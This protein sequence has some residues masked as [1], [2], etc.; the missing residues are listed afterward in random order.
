MRAYKSLAWAALGASLLSGCATQQAAKVEASADRVAREAEIKVDQPA[1]LSSIRS[2]VIYEDRPWIPSSEVVIKQETPWANGD[3]EVT[4]V[5]SF[6]SFAD[7]AAAIASMTGVAVEVG[8]EVD[9]ILKGDSGDE[10]EAEVDPALA[11]TPYLGMSL[12]GMGGTD[13]I[14]IDHNGSLR[15]LL[16]SI[17][18][19]FG[20]SW[21]VIDDHH[22]RIY[23]L[24]SNSWSL[25]ALIGTINQTSKVGSGDS[26]SAFGV[27]E[28]SVWQSVQD[29]V[30]SMLSKHGKAVVSE[31]AGTVTVTDMPAVI[32]K[33]DEYI[34]KLNANL[35]TMV[36]VDVEVYLVEQNRDDNYGIDWEAVYSSITDLANDSG[37]SLG[38]SRTSASIN[39]G[40]NLSFGIIGNSKWQG[41]NA[42]IKALSEQG[43]VT[44]V[45]RTRVL[46]LNNQPVPFKVGQQTAYLK[47]SATSI[48]EGT[49]TTS[50]EQD[51]VDSG[52]FL[53]I[54]PHVM[55]R[56][57]LLLQFSLA[58]RKLDNL[59]TVTSGDTS[60][61]TPETSSREMIQRVA[62]RSG[63]TLIVSGQDIW[64][65]KS[66]LQGVGSPRNSLFGGSSESSDR[67]NVM[68]V[69]IRP[70]IAEH[71]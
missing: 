5:R 51:V 64:D 38:L 6:S 29:T 27:T 28:L 32:A 36:A 33:V 43:K 11:T 40:A 55:D 48:S 42:L 65:L 68:V 50:V 52:F 66:V 49:A 59:N 8:P 3:L 21:Q 62:L 19:R 9:D 15:S 25:A 70:V 53:N 57:S 2:P 60:V 18:A 39:A 24:E 22:V 71:K 34:K 1:R 20:L 7:I 23:G 63:D 54:V 30:S 12:P 31:A 10:A 45:N 44:Q 56:Q 58:L 17:T 46:T 47:S 16:N 69:S 61:Q 37:F 14:T 35:A 67:R 4:L 26:D 41:T 13:M